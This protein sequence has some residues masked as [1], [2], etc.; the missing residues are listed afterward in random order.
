M[1]TRLPPPIRQ[2][3]R[4]SDDANPFHGKTDRFGLPLRREIGESAEQQVFRIMAS[5]RLAHDAYE[6]IE[7]QFGPKLA[8]RAWKRPLRQ[9]RGRKKGSQMNA[10]QDVDLLRRYDEFAHNLDEKKRRSV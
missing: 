1:R 6:A 2:E 4:L 8:K 5:L 10:D 3:A 7:R 9:R